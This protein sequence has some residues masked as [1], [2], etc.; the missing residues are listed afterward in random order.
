[1]AYATRSIR[2]CAVAANGRSAVRCGRGYGGTT[3]KDYTTYS[4]W[5]A[6]AGEELTP[7]PPLD[8][9]IDPDGPLLGARHTGLWTAYY[10]L[11]RDPTLKIA[12]VEREIAGFG[13]SGRNGGWC[14]GGFPMSLGE[15]QRRF[16][17]ERTKE[18]QLAMWATVDEVGRVA[19]A[20]G[21]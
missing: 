13:A 5:L 16:G 20:E 3:G 1:T 15:L 10:L 18:L 17:A 9:S 12:L 14:S 21:I 8:G 11:E 19:A 2:A 4:F 6:T 7:R